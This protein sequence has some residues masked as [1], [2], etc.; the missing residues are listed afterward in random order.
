MRLVIRH[1]DSIVV[2]DRIRQDLGKGNE[3]IIELANSL[4]GPA[5]QIHPIVLDGDKLKAGGR[6]YAATLFLSKC[7]PIRSIGGLLPE[8]DP[9]RLEP[10]FIMCVQHTDLP[11][12]DQLLI[13]IEENVRRKA[14]NKAEEAMGFDRLRALIAELEEKTIGE[15]SH[16]EIARTAQVSAATV[17]MGLRVAAAV[18]GGN[19]ELLDSNSVKGAY[20]KLQGMERMAARIAAV[21]AAVPQEEL[22]R[23]MHCGDGIEWLR[24]LDNKLMD[25]WMFDPPWGI[26]IDEYGSKDREEG[27]WKDDYES[28]I[29]LF[30]GMIP[31]LYR[32]LKDDSYMPVFFG[33][34][35]YSTIKRALE[36]AACCQG[37]KREEHRAIG[38]KVPPVPNIWYKPNKKGAQNDPSRH[39]MNQYEPFF[40]CEKGEP[41]I[42]KQAGGN[43]FVYDMPSRTDRFHTAQKSLM[44]AKEILER[45][46]FGNMKVGDPTAGSFTFLKAAKLLG[47]QVYGCEL[48]EKNYEQGLIYLHEPEAASK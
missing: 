12:K 15:V 48:D 16:R 11:R 6:R 18:R 30:R 7:Q 33:I 26:D 1:V 37:R 25:I 13:E 42:F 22:R 45:Y 2:E 23:G 39:E 5:A 17:T 19:T 8:G 20:N 24:E 10:G 4:E 3:S 14:F 36:H 35:F 47:R 38:F 29:V 32:T 31:E 9:R 44:L 28:A 41:R 21:K 34:Q 40:V 43:V 27:H 46:S